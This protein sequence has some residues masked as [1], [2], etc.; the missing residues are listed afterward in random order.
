MTESSLTSYFGLHFNI[1]KSPKNLALLHALA[2]VCF[3]WLGAGNFPFQ[4]LGKNS[5]PQT[6]T[7]VNL[8]R[9]LGLVSVL[10]FTL[11]WKP[12]MGYLTGWFLVFWYGCGKPQ[13]LN[14]LHSSTFM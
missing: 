13:A 7:N 1:S 8:G 2:G 14:L 4:Y 10:K 6:H 5:W 11:E 9:D 3:C 12:Q